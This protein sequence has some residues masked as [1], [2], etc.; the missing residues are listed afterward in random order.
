MRQERL[1]R[2]NRLPVLVVFSKVDTRYHRDWPD[3]SSACGGE[4]CPKLAYLKEEYIHR[5]GYVLLWQNRAFVLYGKPPANA[6]TGR[7]TAQ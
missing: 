4:D 7:G 3:T 2:K 6:G 1:A 5:L